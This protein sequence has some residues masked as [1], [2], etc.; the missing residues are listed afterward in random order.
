[1]QVASQSISHAHELQIEPIILFGKYFCLELIKFCVRNCGVASLYVEEPRSLHIKP[2]KIQQFLGLTVGFTCLTSAGFQIRSTM[3]CRTT[4]FLL[5]RSLNS[6]HSPPF[7]GLAEAPHHLAKPALEKTR[8]YLQGCPSLIPSLFREYPYVAAWCVAQALSEA[9]GDA[10]HAIYIHIE[11]ALGVSLG[12]HKTR[13]VLFQSFCRVCEKLGLPTRG[14]DR[15]V[16]VYLLHAGVP[17]ALLPHLVQAFVRQEEAFGPPPTQATAMLNRWEDDSLEFLPP[18]VVTPRRAVSWDETAWHATLYARIRQDRKAFA[19]K[20]PIEEHFEKALSNIL[21]SGRTASKRQ[22]GTGAAFSPKPR[23]FWCGDGLALRLP[24]V[25]GRVKLWHDKD[26]HP[27][28]LRGG[29]DW[30]LQQPWPVLLR[31]S[32]GEQDGEI[33]FLPATA[34]FAVFDQATGYMVKESRETSSEIVIDTSNAVVLSRRPFSLDGEPALEAGES[35]FVLF[36]RLG[37]QPIDLVNDQGVMRMRAKLRRRLTVHGDRVANGP[38]GPLYG[39]AATLHIETGS[40]HDETR[41]L[42]VMVGSE[43]EDIGVSVIKG[44]AEVCVATLLSPLPDSIRQ[45]PLRMRVDLLVPKNGSQSMRSSGVALEVWVWPTFKGTDGF[46]FDS[47]TMPQNFVSEQS[48]HAMLDSSGRLSLEAAG[49][50]LAARATFEIEERFIPFDLPWPDV[51]VTRRRQDGAVTVMPNGTRLTIGEENRFDTL[52]IRCPDAKAKLIVRGRQ[53]D[54]PFAHGLSRNLALRELL[55]PASNDKVVLRRGTGSEFLLFEIAR[56]LEPASIKFMPTHPDGVRVRLL[57]ETPV[58]ALALQVE[59]ELGCLEFVEAGLGRRPVSSRPPPWLFVDLPNGNPTEIELAVSAS[60]ISDGLSLARILVRPEVEREE[61]GTWRP[62]RNGRG[63]TYA[64]TFGNRHAG[65][66]DTSLQNRFEALSRWLA[67]C[68]AIECWTEIEASLMSRWQALG[69]AL[70]E[71]P[72]GQGALMMAAAI[73]PPEHT[74][75]SWVPVAHPIQLR[76]RLYGAP[77]AAFAGLSVSPDPGISEMAKLFSLG[78]TR[79]RNQFQ[80]HPTVYFSFANSN[81][82]ENKGVELRGFKPQKFFEI[83]P[84]VDDDPAAGWFWRGASI[85]GPDHWRAA[86]LRFVERLESAE[87]FTGNEAETGSN[88]RQ[89]RVLHH[90]IQ[91]AWE[92]TPKADRPPVPARLEEQEEPN[93][94]DLWAAASLSMLA[95]ASRMGEMEKII[96]ELQ[97]RLDWRSTKSLRAFSSLLRLAPELFTFFLLVWQIAKER[98]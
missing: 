37:S 69:Y 85:L 55:E 94:I 54:R 42:R 14:F 41:H 76:P 61:H 97:A 40:E 9:Y 65:E 81:E 59:D 15:L 84:M 3:A 24:R 31:W 66:L 74:V 34:G 70:A 77:T 95:H 53:E 18:S 8:A 67:D 91:T 89:E 33:E 43:H 39:S 2:P 49:G 80:L 22:F 6:P 87:M 73:Q 46:V 58:D 38:R 60:K 56:S 17:I 52:T 47:E 83:L 26:S 51:V 93:N 28:R 71:Q 1:M 12:Q 88:R 72:G 62:L 45:D 98:P 29:E 11:Q 23:L 32:L 5:S 27:F 63:D 50:Y 10:D 25:E 79:L 4:D 44:F 48:R 16:D 21:E 90:L 86:H 92:M 13:Q 57:F 75:A 64:I 36:T 20:L 30:V 35:G 7:I 19:A 96:E 78:R 68:Y 82:A